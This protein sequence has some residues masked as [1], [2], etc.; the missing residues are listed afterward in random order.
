MLFVIT[1]TSNNKSCRRLRQCDGY[2][3]QNDKKMKLVSYLGVGILYLF[4]LSILK[5][6][7]RTNL[8][9]RGW[10]FFCAKKRG[11]RSRLGVIVLILASFVKIICFRVEDAL[12]VTD[13]RTL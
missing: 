4:Y 6:W 12:R 3:R 5:V 2:L 10:F 9:G 13:V 11:V 7:I 1:T 8:P